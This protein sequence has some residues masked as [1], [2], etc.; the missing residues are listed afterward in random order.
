MSHVPVEN[1]VK[2]AQELIESNQQNISFTEDKTG[3]RKIHTQ[4]ATESNKDLAKHLNGGNS[5]LQMVI[6]SKGFVSK[7]RKGS[8]I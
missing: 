7:I 6:N 3:S 5:A 2:A 4:A 8:Y 1:T